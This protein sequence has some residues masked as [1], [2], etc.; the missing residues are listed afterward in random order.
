MD[1]GLCNQRKFELG[2]SHISERKQYYFKLMKLANLFLMHLCVTDSSV[3]VVQR[4]HDCVVP[5]VS[6]DVLDSSTFSMHLTSGCLAYEQ[7]L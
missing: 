4:D 3:K 7:H 1:H 2:D 5:S 6:A